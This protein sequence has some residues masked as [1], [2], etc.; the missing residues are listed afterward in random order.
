MHKYICSNY[1]LKYCYIVLVNS[2][3][4]STTTINSDT[5]QVDEVKSYDRFTAV[6]CIFLFFVTL[7]V[8]SVYET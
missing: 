4:N 1:Y 8:F 3:F 6:V 7:F 5:H 2:T